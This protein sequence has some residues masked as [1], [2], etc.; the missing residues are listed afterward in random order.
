MQG[1]NAV[2]VLDASRILVLDRLAGR[3]AVVDGS[4]AVRTLATVP[5]DV[6]D[7]AAGPG[8]FVTS[9]PVRASAE[10]FDLEGKSLG[11]LP[12]PRELRDVTSLAFGADRRVVAKT[13]YQEQITLGVPAAPVALASALAGK[14]EGAYLLPDGRGVRVRAQNG[15]AVI[16]VVTQAADEQARSEVV[17]S[18]PIAGAVTA[19]RILGGAGSSVCLRTETLADDGVLSVT[20]RA[21]C[22]DVASGMCSFDEALPAPGLY[23]PRTEVAFGSGRLAWIHPTAEGLAVTSVRIAATEVAP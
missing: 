19:A 11:V 15:A 5:V 18:W 3:V 4:G 13:A 20:R 22:V 10:V 14:R 17:K 7:V 23:V 12:V 16:E 1:P 8:V 21:V 9:S 2:A 6:E